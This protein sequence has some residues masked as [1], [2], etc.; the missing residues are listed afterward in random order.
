MERGEGSISRVP[1]QG[2]LKNVR[3]LHI[4]GV[5]LGGISTGKSVCI[6]DISAELICQC[7]VVA[8]PQ[9]KLFR[10]GGFDVCRRV[11]ARACG[12]IVKLEHRLD[13]LHELIGKGKIAE[14]RIALFGVYTI[15]TVELPGL[16]L[17]SV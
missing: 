5:G 8:D 11:L 14:K 17:A 13:I 16:M 4:Y 10:P 12:L 3:D 1:Q 7:E 2:P 6:P 15:V 9:S